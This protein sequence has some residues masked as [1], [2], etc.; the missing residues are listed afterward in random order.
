MTIIKNKLTQTILI[1]FLF[2]FLLGVSSFIVR[3]TLISDKSNFESQLIIIE[4]VKK[5][6]FKKI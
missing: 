4:T 5:K 6:K 1:G 2:A 3:N